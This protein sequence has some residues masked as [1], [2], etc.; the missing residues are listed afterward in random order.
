MSQSWEAEIA[1]ESAE[2]DREHT[3]Q[4]GLI[5]S[6]LGAMETGDRPAAVK[7]FG[8]VLDA[9]NIHFGDEEVL[10]RQHSYPKY[11][12]HIEE[13]RRMVEALQDLV[14]RFTNGEQLHEQ[15]TAVRGWFAGHIQR[16]DREFS[17]HLSGRPAKDELP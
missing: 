2:L 3:Y 6:L 14:Q 7:L 15:V 9:S 11:G 5:D 13:H 16:M 1:R 8:Q 10:M 4:V 17:A 12:A